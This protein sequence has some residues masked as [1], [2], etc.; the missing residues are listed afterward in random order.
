MEKGGQRG[1]RGG[2]RRRGGAGRGEVGFA[3]G[4]E[5]ALGDHAEDAGGGRLLTRFRAGGG[6]SSRL[7][8]G[9][10]GGRWALVS[11]EHGRR[12]S[13]RPF[14]S[15]VDPQQIRHT[16]AAAAATRRRRR[17]DHLHARSSGRA[18]GPGIAG[19]R[20]RAVE[21][22]R[23]FAS[24]VPLRLR[25]RRASRLATAPGPLARRFVRRR[26]RFVPARAL[27]KPRARVGPGMD[28]AIRGGSGKTRVWRTHKKNVGLRERLTGCS[29]GLSCGVGDSSPST[30]RRS[31]L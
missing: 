15:H 6:V 21:R 9:S 3:R 2:G 30:R 19:T 7:P 22:R 25:G 20:A 26:G 29:L 18:G 14:A 28:F 8:R 13:V 1:R 31:T 24:R 23:S 27:A 16:G 11:H 10:P 17:R 4:A 5:A 12:R